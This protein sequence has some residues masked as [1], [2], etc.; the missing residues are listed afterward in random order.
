MTTI[1]LSRGYKESLAQRIIRAYSNR[2]A[3]GRLNPDTSEKGRYEPRGMLLMTGEEIVSL[4]STIARLMV[5]EISEGDINRTKLTEL[6]GK[7]SLL[8]HAMSSY[9]YWLRGHIEEIKDNFPKQFI[10]L[11]DKAFKENTHKKLPEQIA[12]LQFALDTVISWIVDKDVL[13]ENEAFALSKEGWDIFTELSNKQVERLENEDPI[14]RFIEILQTL[15]TQGKVR[16]EDKDLPDPDRFMGSPQGELIGYYDDLYLYLLPPALWHSLQR[17]CIAE[18]SYFPLSKN[19]FYRILKNRKL[20]ET[21]GDQNTIDVRL[22]GEIKRVLKVIGR[23]I[24]GIGVT[25]VTEAAN[26]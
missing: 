18:G 10:K 20:I 14:K 15:I 3:R 26:A 2:T 1:L 6:Q 25:K 9:I 19:T 4:Q 11:R 8:P 5:I 17:Y 22:R 24:C 16:I 12:F 7:A 13:S 21:R 23:G